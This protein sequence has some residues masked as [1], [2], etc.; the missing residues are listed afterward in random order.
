MASVADGVPLMTITQV[1][2][3]TEFQKGSWNPDLMLMLIEPT[4]YMLMALAERAEIPMVIY[5]GELEDEDEEEEML[6]NT[7]SRR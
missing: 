6:G 2:L 4:A 7:S 3:F 1:I 5:E